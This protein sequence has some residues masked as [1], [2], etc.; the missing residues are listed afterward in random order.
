MRDVRNKNTF[1]HWALFLRTEPTL[2]RKSKRGV[3]VGHSTQIWWLKFKKKKLKLTLFIITESYDNSVIAI[4][5]FTKFSR[6]IGLVNNN[7]DPRSWHILSH[8]LIRYI[9]MHT[10]LNGDLRPTKCIEIRIV[11]VMENNQITVYDQLMSCEEG[12]FQITITWI[13]QLSVKMTL[14]EIILWIISYLCL[15]WQIKILT[16]PDPGQALS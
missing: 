15:T 3:G 7:S 16:A 4:S 12:N 2:I 9:H 5:N 6:V 13:S 10:L 1:V 11:R 8:R 14:P